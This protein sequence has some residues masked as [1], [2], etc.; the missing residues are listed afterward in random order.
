MWV[1][2]APLSPAR[3]RRLGQ[4]DRA[5]DRPQGSRAHHE[6]RSGRGACSIDLL[7]PASEYCGLGL[8]AGRAIFKEAAVV[9]ATWQ[10]N[11]KEAMPP[12]GESQNWLTIRQDISLNQ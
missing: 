4:L 12:A 8:A 3:G 9:T 2:A 11:A 6:H 5:F 1:I 7:G 10:E